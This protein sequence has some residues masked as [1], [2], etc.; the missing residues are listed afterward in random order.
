M[1]HISLPVLEQY[2]KNECPFLRRI[3]CRFHLLRCPR[4]RKRLSRLCADD[5]LIRELKESL[6]LFG[7]EENG[8]RK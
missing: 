1:K 2:R 3:C 6:R 7:S 8:F 4:C 5:L